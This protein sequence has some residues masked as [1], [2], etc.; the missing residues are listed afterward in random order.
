MFEIYKHF[1]KDWQHCLDYSEE[2]ML[3]LYHSES[4]GNVICNPNN[5]YYVGKKWCNVVIKMWKEDIESGILFKHE[6][7]SDPDLP[8]WFLDKVLK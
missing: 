5:G 1:S 8:D 4:Y 3:E 7:Y 6:L 2:S